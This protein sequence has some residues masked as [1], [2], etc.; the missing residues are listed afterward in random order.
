[1]L[2]SCGGGESKTIQ[3][4]STIEVDP[5]TT[6]VSPNILLIISDDQGQD[7]S[8]QYTLSKDLPVTPNLDSLANNGLVFDNLW[9]TPGCTTTRAALITGKYGVNTGVLAIGEELPSSETILHAYLANNP[10]TAH[11]Q[12]ALIGKWHLGG[13][14]VMNSHPNEMGVPYFSGSL[15]GSIPNYSRWTLTTNGQS[16]ESTTYNTTQL[17][18]SAIDWIQVQ[19]QPWFMWL[20]YTAPHLPIHLPPNNLHSQILSGT[21]AD[22][23]NNPRSYYLAAIEA[24]DTEIGRLLDAM[25]DETRNNTLIF[26]IGDNGSPAQVIDRTVY[27]NGSK[28]SLYESGLRVPMLASGKG[29]SRQN[30]R[31]SG[32]I[33]GTDFFA[34]IAELA[35]S[36]LSEIHN[37]VSFKN[38]LNNAD[39]P[40]RE[41]IYADFESNLETGW[42]IR[43]QQ[44]K[45]IEYANGD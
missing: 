36:E 19:T 6:P 31:E 15:T 37:S 22:I 40:A 9:V 12:S 3:D 38:L 17:T 1:M 13:D 11:Y 27:I 28:G 14:N 23:E 18:N 7:A 21:S 33:N 41:Y 16:S 39:S 45:L 24:M 5:P 8:A 42:A 35:G 20:A 26:F 2:S 30:E 29:V 10:A 44:Y 32:L 43:N 25:S 4:Q 34:T